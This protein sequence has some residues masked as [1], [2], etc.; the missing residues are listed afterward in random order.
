M[1]CHYLMGEGMFRFR[2]KESIGDL[3][4]HGKSVGPALALPQ[5]E[6]TSGMS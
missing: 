2:G 5:L 4:F 6:K 1:G 3:T